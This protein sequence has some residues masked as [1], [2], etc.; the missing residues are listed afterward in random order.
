MPIRVRA[1]VEGQRFRSAGIPVKG[2]GLEVVV[3]V[4]IPLDLDSIAD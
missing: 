1:M 3:G 4:E 2:I